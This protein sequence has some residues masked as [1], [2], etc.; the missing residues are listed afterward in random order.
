MINLHESMGPGWDRTRDPWIC[1]Q[2]RASV[3]RHVTDCATRPGTL[4]TNLT[5]LAT[6]GQ[7]SIGVKLFIGTPGMPQKYVPGKKTCC[8]NSHRLFKNIFGICLC[9]M[10]ISLSNF[11]ICSKMATFLFS[12]YFGG[13]FCYH[14]NGKSQ[15][16][17]IRRNWWKTIFIF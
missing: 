12:A 10:L 5:Y 9:S 17:L 6:P 13:H 2:T 8:D 16:K 7:D 3:A 1:S 11:S 4:G 14:S 15:N